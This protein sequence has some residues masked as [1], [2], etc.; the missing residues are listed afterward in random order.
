[1]V[2]IHMEG[3]ETNE[4]R[5]I[6]SKTEAHSAAYALAARAAATIITKYHLNSN[7]ECP[8]IDNL[9]WAEMY[10]YTSTALYRA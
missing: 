8:Y 1:M 5:T 2:G 7:A 4:S 9:L 3:E 6:L 10:P